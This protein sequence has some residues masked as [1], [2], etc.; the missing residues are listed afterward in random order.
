MCITDTDAGRQVV[1]LSRFTED[2]PHNPEG[3]IR[4]GSKK[5]SVSRKNCQMGWSGVTTQEKLQKYPAI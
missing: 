4:F 2:R 3:E 5:S 1:Q